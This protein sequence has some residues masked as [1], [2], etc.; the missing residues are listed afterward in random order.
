MS[1][2]NLGGLG[3][4]DGSSEASMHKMQSYLLQL[5]EQ[6]RYVLGNLG[7]ENFEPGVVETLEQ[8]AAVGDFAREVKDAAGNYS[9][10]MQTASKLS[11]EVGAMDG[12]VSRVEQTADGLKSTVSGLSGRVSALE[13]DDNSVTIKLYDPSIDQNFEARVSKANEMT[14]PAI[15]ESGDYSGTSYKEN[16]SQRGFVGCG[17]TSSGTEVFVVGGNDETWVGSG[18]KLNLFASPTG[19]S[20]WLDGPANTITASSSIKTGSD[21][22]LKTDIRDLDI[23]AYHLVMGLRSRAYRYKNDK[24]GTLQHGVVAQEAY[25]VV[26]QC[27]LEGLGLVQGTPDD[28][29]PM[30]VAYEQLIAPM[31]YV[32]Q[33]QQ[34]M[35]QYMDHRLR[36]IENR[37]VGDMDD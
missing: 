5:T 23:R 21:R 20:I 12:R 15:V 19:P 34:E 3:K 13:Q 18:S 30:S 2:I 10:V 17:T 35:M 16:G 24:T 36:E 22:R 33:T 31:L 14:T 7:T 32:I 9:V 27:G 1:Q 28:E 11:T 26:K 37:L 4:L 6:L 25:E 8:V 29:A